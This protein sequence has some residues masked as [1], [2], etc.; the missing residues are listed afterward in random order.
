MIEQQPV[1]G[2]ASAAQ[3]A[4]ER[5]ERERRRGVRSAERMTAFTDAV[6]AIA[7]T[8]L[9]LPLM[10]SATD[11]AARDLGA[12]SWLDEHGSQI[13]SF[14]ISFVLIAGYWLG[15][16]AL[17]E[18]VRGYTRAMV[19]INVFWML[20]IVWLPVPT[21]MIGSMAIFGPDGEYDRALVALYIGSIILN[22]LAL[23]ALHL[24]I[25]RSAQVWSLTEPPTV[26]GLSAS[27]AMIILSSLALA[28]ALIWP[29]VNLFAMF[30]MMLVRPL[31]VAIG[32]VLDR[33]V[34]AAG[35][36]EALERYSDDDDDEPDGGSGRA[37]SRRRPRDLVVDGA[38]AREREAEAERT[39]A[40]PGEAA[41]VGESGVDGDASA[42]GDAEPPV[43]RS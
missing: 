19:W 1:E 41:E 15:H 30:L 32:L 7:M 24:S 22:A 14:L 40:V 13:V 17:F 21:A 2:Q 12:V 34:P 4:P 31:E 42:D 28:V 29:P 27:L 25:M 5:V 6:V 37:G 20:T 35:D 43:E 8:L 16:H 26:R 18:R 23:A 10:E 33:L 9:I 3:P 11:L 36:W 38:L 39:L